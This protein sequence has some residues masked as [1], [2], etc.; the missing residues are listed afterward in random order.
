LFV[1]QSISYSP[2]L[3]YAVLPTL[4]SP[5]VGNVVGAGS[6]LSL[7]KQDGYISD[8]T[9]RLSVGITARSTVTVLGNYRYSTFPGAS[10]GRDYRSYAAGGQYAYTINRNA[11]LHLGY[12]RRQA[13]YQHSVDGGPVVEHD[14][15][16]GVA[17]RRPLSFSRRTTVDF[18][19]GSAIVNTPLAGG[20]APLLATGPAGL[21]YRVIGSGGLSHDFGRT[22]KARL[23]YNRGVG[24]VEAFRQPIFS[25]AVNLAIAGFFS[26]R[27]D[28]RANG[29]VSS[30]SLNPDYSVAP[31]PNRFRSYT[32]DA[33]LRVGFTSRWAMYAEYLFYD[34]GAGAAVVL[35]AGVPP[36]LQRNSARAGLALWLPMVKR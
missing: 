23:A 24:Y 10:A 28:F 4:D 36:S 3:F 19:V 2:S 13:D 29:G 32:A 30:G 21:Q 1:N 20:A 14:I 9:A 31:T 17:Y 16:A 5:G 22:W 11:T 33:R 27:I 25:D 6:D 7:A 12:T 8:T 26:R 34:Y 15:D 35:P 18:N